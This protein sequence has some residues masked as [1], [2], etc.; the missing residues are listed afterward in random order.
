MKMRIGR[1]VISAE[2]LAT[3]LEVV[4]EF[5]S[6]L[7][8]IEGSNTPHDA[9]WPET[10]YSGSTLNNPMLPWKNV[11]IAKLYRAVGSEALVDAHN[12]LLGIHNKALDQL[13]ETR[14]LLYEER[15]K[16][17]REARLTETYKLRMASKIRVMTDKLRE[18]RGLAR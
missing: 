16:F 4:D 6:E 10:Q 18:A 5:G 12:A 13:S 3:T 8:E 15:D 9:L 2:G 1:N 14:A 11:E 7:R 17:V